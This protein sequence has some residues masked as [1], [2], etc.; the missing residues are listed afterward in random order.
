MSD[1]R[2]DREPRPI[3]ADHLANPVNLIL[4]IEYV[5]ELVLNLPV[6]LEHAMLNQNASFRL[7]HKIKH[8]SLER[9]SDAMSVILSFKTSDDFS[10]SFRVD[11]A[12]IFRIAD[13]FIDHE[14]DA[15]PVGLRIH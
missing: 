13:S 10:I 2:D 6:I 9:A 15:Y 12:D 7:I 4:P 14:V 1:S 3:M 11:Q 5:K 8:W